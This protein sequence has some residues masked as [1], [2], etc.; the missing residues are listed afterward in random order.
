MSRMSMWRKQFNVAELTKSKSAGN[1]TIGYCCGK[2]SVCQFGEWSL[3][4]GE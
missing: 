4:Y 1:D 2:D 3:K